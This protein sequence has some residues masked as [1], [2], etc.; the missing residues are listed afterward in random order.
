MSYKVFSLSRPDDWFTP[1]VE[2][3]SLQLMRVDMTK[4]RRGVKLDPYKDEDC[5]TTEEI[6]FEANHGA[7]V[8]FVELKRLRLPPLRYF[9]FFL[10][11]ME[12]VSTTPGGYI[13]TNDAL[14]LMQ[15]AL[16]DLALRRELDSSSYEAL[17]PWKRLRVKRSGL[18]PTLNLL[19][20]AVYSECAEEW[21][22]ESPALDRAEQHI[23]NNVLRY[24]KAEVWKEE[25]CKTRLNFKNGLK[26]NQVGPDGSVNMSHFVS[27]CEALDQ[28]PHTL[29]CTFTVAAPAFALMEL[30]VEHMIK[31]MTPAIQQDYLSLRYLGTLSLVAHPISPPTYQ[32]KEALETLAAY[33]QDL[34]ELAQEAR[35]QETPPPPPSKRRK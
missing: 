26:H 33:L 7:D 10:N 9:P 23:L 13:K 18:P 31:D 3:N 6:Y 11:A 1:T 29:K 19:W 17:M 22:K 5:Q 28:D 16:W 35:E 8:Q 20:E 30:C 12:D 21:P 27:Y 14:P 24:Y 15:V 2:R 4:C 25:S 32:H 34:K